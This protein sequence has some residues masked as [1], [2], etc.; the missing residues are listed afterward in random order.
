MEYAVKLT[1][2]ELVAGGDPAE[3]RYVIG[4]LFDSLTR[5]EKETCLSGLARRYERL[6]ANP[7]QSPTTSQ[8]VEFVGSLDLASRQFLINYTFDLLNDANQQNCLDLLEQRARVKRVAPSEEDV[9]IQEEYIQKRI[10]QLA[11]LQWQGVSNQAAVA[12]AMARYQAFYSN[13]PPVPVGELIDVPSTETPPEPVSY[14]TVPLI[15]AKR[16]GEQPT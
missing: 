14:V 6:P 9:K 10:R 2:D 11:D 4:S 7:K 8:I 12:M 3:I 1:R 16:M 13:L 15:P 5:N